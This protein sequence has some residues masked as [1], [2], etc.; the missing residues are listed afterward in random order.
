M[1]IIS[2]CLLGENC[3]YNGGSNFSKDVRN[4]IKGKNY[5]AVCPELA[6]GFSVPRPPVELK[7]GRALRLCGE[8]VTDSFYKGAMLSLATAAEESQRVMEKIDLA[9]LKAKSPSC[10][11]G[12]IYDGSFSGRLVDGDGIFARLLIENGIEVITEEDVT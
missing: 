10:G 5:V 2:A 7:G 3:R 1:Y 6:G 12:Q 9:I 11:S 4:F 8:D